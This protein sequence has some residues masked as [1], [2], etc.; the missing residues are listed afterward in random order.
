MR[1][2]KCYISSF[3]KLKNFT[4]Y[5]SDGLNTIKE[6]NG[7]GKSTLAT[8]IKA[9]FYGLNCGKRSVSENERL[10]FKPWNST[11]RF[12]GHLCFVQNDRSYRI[13][14]YF[15]NKESEDTVKLFD[16]QTGKEL[17]KSEN[18]GLSFFK[19]D[20]EGFLSTTYF[21]QK[22][23]QIKSNSSL[24]AKYNSV[25]ETEETDDFD[26][27]LQLVEDKAKYYKSRGDKG[28]ITEIKREL[29]QIEGEIFQANKA[30]ETI[31]LL[32]KDVNGLEEKIGKLKTS[33]NQLREKLA[34]A[35]KGEAQALKRERYNELIA[36]KQKLVAKKNEI[37]NILNGNVPEIG[38]ILACIDCNNELNRIISTEN[39]LKEDVKTLECEKPAEKRKKKSL[40]I[41]FLGLGFLF[42][43]LLLVFTSVV[44]FDAF[45]G[46]TSAVLGL[47][48]ISIGL[49]LLVVFKK[50][51]GAVNQYLT[52]ITKKKTE[53]LEYE[54]I[55]DQY[56]TKIDS[57]ISLFNVNNFSD[58]DAKLTQIL[59]AVKA[60]GEIA[61]RLKNI[62]GSILSLGE[63]EIEQVKVE[64]V[65]YLNSQLKY[66]NEEYE[67]ETIRLANKR[68]AIKNHED[69][70]SKIAEYE[71]RRVE[72]K[73]ILNQY[74]EEYE[75]LNLT[76]Q[77]LKKADENLKIK[78]RAPLQSS[79][80]KYLNC[81]N[82]NAVANI[83]ID[84]FVTIEEN[85]GKKVTDY[86]SKGYQ[87]L[88]EICKRFALID[89]LF[90]EE[91]PFIILDDP[92]YN[93]DDQKLSL[94]TKLI[95]D[96]SNEYQILYLICHE[97]RRC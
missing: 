34:L 87:N 10:K 13:E 17:T 44:G 82:G 84:F 6:N 29:T 77:Y 8:F 7:W 22:D 4:Y 51:N 60:Y 23:F 31:K 65:N 37:E 47:I 83:D 27:A 15:G 38:K 30:I 36:E 2:V 21:S 89:V 61:T 92:F 46:I 52:L 71:S 35:G 95:K 85:E 49:S 69:C 3:G 75:I 70:A 63:I 11:E 88:F 78:Y 50:G 33:A 67:I 97:S 90:K 62:K 19:I 57:F 64:D 14:R 81:L 91:K 20:E 59:N 45:F 16:E 28:A 40:P 73:E 41:T 93:F 86:Y 58:R 32:K 72:L 55:K 94:A 24:T 48:F 53:L 56:Q 43:S 79:L 5:F 68:A 80:N 18:L 54:E 1:L 66:I 9:M 74:C 12:G 39:L 76:S 96:L 25:Y 26:R 42:L